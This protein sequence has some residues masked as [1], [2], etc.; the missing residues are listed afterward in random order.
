[1]LYRGTTLSRVRGEIRFGV[2]DLGPGTY[3][4]D[5]PAHAGQFT[6]GSRVASEPGV[7]LRA[8][9]TEA[10]LGRILDLTRPPHREAWNA[11]VAQLRGQVRNEQYLRLLEAY[12]GEIGTTL[13][14]FD[15]IIGPNYLRQG[16]TQINVRNPAV[17]D[18]VL[19]VAEEVTDV[20]EGG[21]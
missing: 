5:T 20:V 1:M 21:S 7:I 14:R 9:V 15:T 2:D 8:E 4:G 17:L 19:E 10:M 18:R 11:L 13:D 3:F 6:E 16:G 12:L